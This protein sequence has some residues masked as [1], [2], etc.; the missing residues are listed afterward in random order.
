VA[1]EETLSAGKLA[2]LA[3]AAGFDLCGFARAEP[4][5][6]TALSGWLESGFAADMDWLGARLEDRLDV[7]RLLPGAKTVVALACNYW[8]GDEPSLVA[9]YA[10][11]RD[12]HAT[13]RDRVRALR[14]T[15][16]AAWPG[17]Q[18]YGSVDASPVMEKVWAARAGLGYVGR[19]GLLITPEHGSWVVLAALIIDRAVDVYADGPT[20]DLCAGCRLCVNACPTEA[21][22][23]DQTVDARLCLSYQT[24]ENVAAVPE[25][26]RTAMGETVFGCDLCQTVCPHNAAPLFGG[27]RFAPRAVAGLDARAIA[28]MSRED[29]ARWI[30]GTALARAQYDGLRRNAAYA[31]GV[32]GDAGARGVL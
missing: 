3:R 10:R 9:R 6:P 26:L 22:V 17:A 24:I 5:P 18:D 29:Y 12:Y 28:A 23:A 19:H 32:A 11:G 27:D 15:F 8:R 30:P 2:A 14:R 31:L 20:A 13:L 21:I 4:I 25:P 16:R 7:R 1:A